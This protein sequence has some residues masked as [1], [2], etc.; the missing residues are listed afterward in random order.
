MSSCSSSKATVAADAGT[1]IPDAAPETSVDSSSPDARDA[2]ADSRVDAPTPGGLGAACTTH[3]DCMSGACIP[4]GDAFPGGY[5]SGTCM[6][7]SDCGAGGVCQPYLFRSSTD[8]PEPICLLG[9]GS[10]A[11]CR[12]QYFCDTSKGPGVCMPQ[13]CRRTAGACA[14]GECNQV[15]GGCTP[16]APTA[17]YP[18][19]FPPPP[20]I[21]KQAGPVLAHPTFVP[22]F[23]SNDQD[24]G[25]PV[26]DM[27]GFF[28][29]VGQTN[30]WRTLQEY[31][32]SA[33]TAV[34]PVMLSQ[35]APASIADDGSATS[36]L[37]MLLA[38][39]IAGD[40]GGTP[41]PDGST[42]YI[43]VLPTTTT[44]MRFGGQSCTAFGG[45]HDEMTVNGAQVPYVVMPRCSG[46]AVGFM[47]NLDLFTAAASHELV[48]GSTD[49]FPRTSPA[50]YQVD[51]AHMYFDE[52]NSGA[53]IGDMCENDPEAF[54]SFADFA[55]FV[56]RIWSNSAAAAGH[57]PCVPST[58][59]PFFGS[60]PVL[61]GTTS[62]S[63]PQGTFTSDAVVIP[64]GQSKTVPID[65]YSDGPTAAWTVTVV[66]YACLTGNGTLLDITLAPGAGNATCGAAANPTSCITQSCTG[67]NGDVVNATIDV[68]AAG[69][70]TQH[71][72]T[73]TELFLI[74]STQ[75]TG[76]TAM[77]HIGW[78]LVGN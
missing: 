45:Y 23:F 57:D 72:A 35:S 77:A 67:S 13:D 39:F 34:K 60:A 11:E 75:G 64:V 18:A 6:S 9:C 66:D 19:A 50:W 32:V 17:G 51:D 54:W 2:V 42:L 63:I 21:Q 71:Q 56:Q 73:N 76:N 25:A 69:G 53:E 41:A 5:C 33:P 70:P 7:S 78:G 20:Q 26:A 1:S 16:S 31:G 49:P 59:N 30:M 55:F 68:V 37:Q 15:T 48:E 52:A 24:P 43:V 65:L 58:G 22:I 38:S 40:A 61:G 36:P 12:Q 14:Q 8:F 44:V 74:T 29:G 3:G 10:S 47:N 62:L 46:T 4:A 27:V 28:Q